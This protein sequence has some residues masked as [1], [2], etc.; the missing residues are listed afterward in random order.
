[1][2]TPNFTDDEATMVIDP[3]LGSDDAR[4]WNWALALVASGFF[5]TL[6]TYLLL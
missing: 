1:M 3:W 4:I 2:G 5:I 6:T